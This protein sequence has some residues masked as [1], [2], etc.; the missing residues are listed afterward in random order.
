M[1]SVVLRELLPMLSTVPGG[2]T[3]T[4]PLPDGPAPTPLPVPAELPIALFWGWQ[5]PDVLRVGDD[6]LNLTDLMFT[7]QRLVV[8]RGLRTV[9]EAAVRQPAGRVSRSYEM[10]DSLILNT[11]RG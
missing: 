6:A 5:L 10:S 7:N 2:P 3:M 8:Q 11:R 1:V 4:P 9:V